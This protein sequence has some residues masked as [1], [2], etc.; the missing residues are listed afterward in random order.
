MPS[1][2]EVGNRTTADGQHPFTLE[3]DRAFLGCLMQLPADATRRVLAGMR[4][5]DARSPA[6]QR[7]LWLV[8]RLVTEGI[9]PDPVV[10]LSAARNQGWLVDE[11]RHEQFAHWLIDTFRAAPVPEAATVLKRDLLEDALRRAVTAKA[12]QV[13]DIAEHG[14]IDRLH[15]LATFDTDR[16]TDL[17]SRFA[18]AARAI[19]PDTPGKPA[20]DQ[21]SASSDRLCGRDTTRT[22]APGV[23]SADAAETGSTP[24]RH[25]EVRQG[26]AA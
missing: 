6:A 24:L 7:V 8:I 1:G 14:Q 12:Q 16:I 23:E 10:L 19:T 9:N 13:L 17:W 20:T 25:D 22:T 18:E 3:T 11:H 2:T 15:Q 5:E 4:A 26:R 21:I